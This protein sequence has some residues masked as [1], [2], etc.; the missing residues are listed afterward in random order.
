MNRGDPNKQRR[1]TRASGLVGGRRGGHLLGLRASV[2]QLHDANLLRVL[3][4]RVAAVGL[5]LGAV[6]VHCCRGKYS[7]QPKFIIR[8]HAI[9]GMIVDEKPFDA[10]E[11]AG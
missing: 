9:C 10:T 6:G 8:R 11:F 7:Q 5:D 4:H 3:L 1:V 2:Q